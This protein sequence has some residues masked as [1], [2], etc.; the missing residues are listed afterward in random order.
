MTK[1]DVIAIMLRQR[2]LAAAQTAM[3]EAMATAGLDPKKTY[4]FVDGQAV[5]L[6]EDELRTMA[7][8]R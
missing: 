8:K 2:E 7:A 4:K 1:N 6:T 3:N 5:E